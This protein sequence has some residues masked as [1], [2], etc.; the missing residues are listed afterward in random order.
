MN[1]IK[2]AIPKK[3]NAIAGELKTFTKSFNIK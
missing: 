3:L 2:A 1:Y